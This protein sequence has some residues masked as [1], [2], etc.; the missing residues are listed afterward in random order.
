MKEREIFRIIVRTMGVALWIGSL[1]I[2]LKLWPVH[3]YTAADRAG[4]AVAYFLSGLV[5]LLIADLLTR[6]FY[7][8]D[9]ASPWGS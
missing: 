5:I 6:L 4:G 1:L 7:R 8:S 9:N 2:W 3:Y